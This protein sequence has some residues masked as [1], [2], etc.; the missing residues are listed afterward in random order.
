MLFVKH[1]ELECAPLRLAANQLW[2]LP[3]ASSHSAALRVILPARYMRLG[4]EVLDPP[5]LQKE[6]CVLISVGP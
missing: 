2:S 5:L 6:H 1:G 4:R 3:A